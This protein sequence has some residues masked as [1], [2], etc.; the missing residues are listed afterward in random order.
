MCIRDSRELRAN[1]P[2][3]GE[4]MEVDAFFSRRPEPGGPIALIKLWQ[5]AVELNSPKFLSQM[6]DWQDNWLTGLTS[7]QCELRDALFGPPK[8]WRDNS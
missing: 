2:Y 6:D 1:G 3:D 8:D 7:E 4:M 5:I